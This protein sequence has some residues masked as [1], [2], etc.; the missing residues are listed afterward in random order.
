MYLKADLQHWR[1]TAWFVDAWDPRCRCHFHKLLWERQP[2]LHHTPVSHLGPNVLERLWLRRA[3][4]WDGFLPQEAGWQAKYCLASPTCLHTN[5]W[6]A[7][8]LPQRT[9][10]P[11][12]LQMPHLT[13]WR[14]VREILK[15]CARVLLQSIKKQLAYFL[16]VCFTSE[17]GWCPLKQRLLAKAGAVFCRALTGVHHSAVLQAELPSCWGVWKRHSHAL[18]TL[19]LA[20]WRAKDRKAG[21]GS[22]LLHFSGFPLHPH[23]VSACSPSGLSERELVCPSDYPTLT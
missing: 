23:L 21:L 11:P 8:G 4:R 7:A 16:C 20:A 14:A 9:V 6:K 22:Y 12:I 3:P 10:P 2:L 1:N 15:G 5:A 18:H 19:L 13:S 17:D